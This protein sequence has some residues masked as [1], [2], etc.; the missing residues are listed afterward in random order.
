MFDSTRT[1][2]GALALAVALIS[3]SG[4][5]HPADARPSDAGSPNTA[6]QRALG[7]LTAVDHVPGAAATIGDG[8]G[9]TVL[10]SGVAA[11]G[12][13]RPVPADSRF[14]VGSK[15]KSFVATVVLQLVGEHRVV[16]DAPVDRYLPGLVR[17]KG[18]DGRKITVRELLQHTSGIPD[19]TDHIDLLNALAHPLKHYDRGD[20]IKIA[21]A[22]PSLFPPGTSWSYSNTNYLVAGLLIEKITGRPYAEEIERRIIQP[23]G[24]THTYVPADETGIPGPHPHGYVQA[25]PS[26]PDL[27]DRTRFNPSIV[28]AAGAMISTGSDL[29]RFYAALLGGRLLRP[30]ELHAMMT[31]VPTSGPPAGRRYGLGLQSD[32]LSCGGVF[33]G[34]GG[35]V[36]GFEAAGGATTDGRQVTVMA[37]LDPGLDAQEADVAAVVDAA[38]CHGAQ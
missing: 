22:S 26:K 35:D 24:L 12:T 21:L 34:H 10:S 11:V 36:F 28:N 14:R 29:N 8:S 33:W 32:P 5:A 1:L 20:L 30:A 27:L 38:L 16:L 37:T 4:P 23:L 7:K 3:A 18:G 9:R 25:D 13:H 2:G 17:G 19:Y 6:V 31:T 15:T